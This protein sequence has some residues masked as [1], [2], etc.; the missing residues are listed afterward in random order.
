MSKTMIDKMKNIYR[1]MERRDCYFSDSMSDIDFIN[2]FLK[3]VDEKYAH[4]MKYQGE[5]QIKL[6]KGDAFSPDGEFP[7]I[8]LANISESLTITLNYFKID[9]LK[10]LRCLKLGVKNLGFKALRR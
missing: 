5:K 1:D 4:F 10:N 9:D 6:Y 2:L 3:H 8:K 7:I